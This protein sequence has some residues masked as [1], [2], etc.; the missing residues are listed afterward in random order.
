MPADDALGARCTPLP[1][2]YRPA[3]ADDA[4]AC[5][6]L[7][8][9]TRENAVSAERLAALGITV[10]SWGDDIRSGALPGHVCLSGG[11]LVGYCFGAPATGEVVVLA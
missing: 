6:A 2:V 7:R 4:A 9:Q 10:K 5:V 3:T 8:G 1:L 11:T